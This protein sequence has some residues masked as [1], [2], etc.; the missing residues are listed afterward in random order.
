MKVTQ[1]QEVLLGVFLELLNCRIHTLINEQLLLM[2]GHFHGLINTDY[3]LW[4]NVVIDL[5]GYGVN[6]LCFTWSLKKKTK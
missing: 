5:G 2:L 1:W 6:K 3:Y 4:L